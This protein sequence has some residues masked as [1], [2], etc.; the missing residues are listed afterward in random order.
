MCLKLPNSEKTFILYT[1]ASHTG[2]GAGLH[3]MQESREVPIY[4][5]SQKLNKAQLN[6]LTVEKECLAVV[7][8]IRKFSKYLMGKEFIL[9]SDHKALMWLVENHSRGGRLTR[10]ALELQSYSFKIHHIKGKDNQSADFLS[11]Y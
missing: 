10:W 5:A 4:F 1:D 9:K 11:R 3:Q 6:Y 7:W 8:A 2:L